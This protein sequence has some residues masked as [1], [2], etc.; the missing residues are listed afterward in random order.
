[1][2]LLILLFFF[3]CTFYYT[4]VV[5]LRFLISGHE[6]C[7]EFVSQN[8]N[9][10]GHFYKFLTCSGVERNC[11]K[12]KTSRWSVSLS[13]SSISRV[14]AATFTYSETDSLAA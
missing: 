5:I 11:M 13:I 9:N 6:K 10:T 3:D 4:V 14:L 12:R 2:F 8:L 1:M 7:A